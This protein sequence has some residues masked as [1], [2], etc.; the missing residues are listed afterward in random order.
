MSP[1]ARRFGYQ[2]LTSVA[3][4]R[5]VVLLAILLGLAAACRQPDPTPFPIPAERSGLYRFTVSP[6]LRGLLRVTEDAVVIDSLPAGCD[7]ATSTNQTKMMVL[8]CRSTGA[9]GTQWDVTISI[10][11]RDPLHN[12]SYSGSER[13]TRVSTGSACAQTKP[14]PYGQPVCVVAAPT[15]SEVTKRTSGSLRL[16]LL[17]RQP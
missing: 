13:S 14:G 12:S 2:Q 5:S 17:E 9:G 8:L 6:D 1:H 3:L 15:S 4:S 10:D 16:E 11:I 7:R